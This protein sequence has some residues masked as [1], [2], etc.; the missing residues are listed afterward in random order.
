MKTLHHTRHTGPATVTSGLHGTW[1]TLLQH[2]PYRAS[3]LDHDYRP[4]DDHQQHSPTVCSLQSV[5]RSLEIGWHCYGLLAGSF[6]IVEAVLLTLPVHP[7]RDF[8]PSKQERTSA[9]ELRRR[10]RRE[11]PYVRIH[12]SSPLSAMQMTHMQKHNKK[13][14]FNSTNLFL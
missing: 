2:A 4:R 5:L 14:F 1:L 12:P 7:R 10:G 6:Q 9:R 8:S 3:K 11:F 13:Y